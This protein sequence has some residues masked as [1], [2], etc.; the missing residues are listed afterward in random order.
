MISQLFG[1][2]SLVFS[3]TEMF[4][5]NQSFVSNDWPCDA[6]AGFFHDANSKR[7]RVTAGNKSCSVNPTSQTIQDVHT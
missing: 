4:H 2:F 5:V 1:G 7:C 6:D 3:E